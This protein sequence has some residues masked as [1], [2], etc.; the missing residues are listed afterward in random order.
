MYKIL[1]LLMLFTFYPTILSAQ[2]KNDETTLDEL[3]INSKA[4]KKLIKHKI[5]GTPAFNSI[6]QDEFIVTGVNEV[7]KG[8]VKSV[9][10]Y[11]NT[12]FVDVVDV[13]S[14]KKFDTNYLDIE[15]GVLVYEIAENRDLGKIISDC[16]VKFIVSKNHKGAFKVDLSS[17]D[18]PDDKFF[19]GFK[20]LS[21]TNKDENNIYLRLFEDGNY[22]SYTEVYMN[23]FTTSE[24]IV[25]RI[26]PGF[27][28]LKMTFEIE[29]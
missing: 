9:S 18:L 17:L 12:R 24:K 20:V 6:S 11:F 1:L 19:I 26:M 2:N 5:S 28:H 14:G 13:V 10:F 3:I 7:P 8:K 22:V 4:K 25:K 15:L 21:Q 27:A 29:Q 23:D 16:E